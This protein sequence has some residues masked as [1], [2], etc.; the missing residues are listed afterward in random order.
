LN[1]DQ[2]VLVDGIYKLNDFQLSYFLERNQ[3]EICNQQ[4]GVPNSFFRKNHAP[5]ET[6]R[7]RPVDNAKADDYVAGNL[8]YYVLTSKWIFEGIGSQKGIKRLRNGE[9]SPFQITF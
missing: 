1:P 3:T 4:M 7:G 8:M 6:Y 5:E 9:R 2:F